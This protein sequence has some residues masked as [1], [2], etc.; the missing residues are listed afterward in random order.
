MGSDP[1]LAA[2]RRLLPVAGSKRCTASRSAVTLVPASSAAA[3]A[4]ATTSGASPEVPWKRRVAPSSST[5]SFA[6]ANSPSPP[7]PKRRSSGR[8]PISTSRPVAR[9]EGVRHKADAPAGGLDDARRRDAAGHQVHGRRADEGRHEARR[10]QAIDLR[11]RAGLLDAAAVHDDHHVGQGH[12]LHLVVR[13]E[14]RGRLEPV[15]Q[16]ADLGA[17][18]HAQLGVEVRQRLVEQEG[19]R[20]AHDGAAHGHALALAAG[21]LARLAL[22]ERV[23][24][25]Q[26]RR[27][28]PRAARCP[29]WARR[30][31]CRP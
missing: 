10:G 17:H 18:L 12:G 4:T 27:L 31:S 9:L 25:E 16:A 29:A 28:A 11:R 5:K 26:P 23:D 24:G 8:T 19:L 30:D 13:D 14:D 20:L 2:R 22:E 3:A 6:K 15:V 7:E 21:Q 1:R